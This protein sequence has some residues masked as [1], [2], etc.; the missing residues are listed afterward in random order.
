MAHIGHVSTT[1]RVEPSARSVV[2]V[3]FSSVKGGVGTSVTSAALALLLA[4]DT[5]RPTYLVDIGGGDQP[6]I[7]G[8]P[9][10]TDGLGS[11]L[12]SPDRRLSDLAVGVTDTLRLVASGDQPLPDDS[13]WMTSLALALDDLRS[14]A[15]VVVDAGRRDTTDHLDPLADRRLL[16]MRPCYVALRHVVTAAEHWDGLVLVRPPDRV[17]T[18]RDVVSVCDVPLAAEITMTPDVSRAVDAGVLRSR[19]PTTFVRSLMPIVD[20]RPRT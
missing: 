4:R 6:D 15:H 11:W 8:L 1:S 12:S 13:S 9:A 20:G 5:S 17:L 16:V 7:L 18:T 10:V 3:I 19:L 2:F 14:N